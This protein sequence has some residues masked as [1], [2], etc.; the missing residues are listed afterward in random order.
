[1]N[2]LIAR[3]RKCASSPSPPRK[4]AV[5]SDGVGVLRKIL[6]STR[7]YRRRTYGVVF[8]NCSR[9][10]TAGRSCAKLAAQTRKQVTGNLQLRARAPDSI[11]TRALL[12][13]LL[14]NKDTRAGRRHQVL[15]LI[16][17]G[18][19]HRVGSRGGEGRSPQV[20]LPRLRGRVVV[21]QVSVA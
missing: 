11:L 13:G 7:S 18:N 2:T 14:P 5:S 4:S 17:R 10:T 6:H 12:F 1:M 20:V 9:A 21:K 3:N 15:G 19:R 16:S 8:L